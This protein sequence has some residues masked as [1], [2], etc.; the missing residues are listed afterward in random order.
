MGVLRAADTLF[1]ASRHPT[2]GADVSHRGG[3]RG[4]LD[5]P[6]PDRVSIPDYAGNMMFN[7]LG[8]LTADARA[9]LLVA[10]WTTG[11][12]VQLT[13]RATVNWEPAAVAAF[14]GAQRLVEFA[15]DAVVE[16]RGVGLITRP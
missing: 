10:D 14:A 5:V 16:R 9:G 2:S 6:A 8:N 7:T 4:F 13:G 3:V 1:I 15:I 12:L 11:T